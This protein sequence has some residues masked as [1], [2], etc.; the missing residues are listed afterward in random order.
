MV[1]ADAI[2]RLMAV[3]GVPP[4]AIAR[5]RC[6]LDTRDNA[7]FASSMLARRGV[8]RVVVI[9]CVWHLPR[10]ERAFR[11]VGLEVE[12]V[13]VLGPEPTALQRIYRRAR[14]RFASWNDARRPVRIV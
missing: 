10:A 4:D 6:S 8:S 12:G 3:R 5:E 11:S 2:A 7:R 13:G 1:E 9:T 14:E